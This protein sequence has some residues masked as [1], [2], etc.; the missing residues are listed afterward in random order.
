MPAYHFESPTGTPV[1]PRHGDIFAPIYTSHRGDDLDWF[2]RVIYIEGETP[3]T[4]Y[5][6]NRDGELV[7]PNTLTL[8]LEP[9]PL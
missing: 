6:Q 5:L 7:F 1:I 4:Y 3:D 9:D 2:E 8:R